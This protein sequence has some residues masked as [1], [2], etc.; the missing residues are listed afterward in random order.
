MSD[1]T[2]S[3]LEDKI[4]MVKKDLETLRAQGSAGRKLEIL[5][6]YLAYLEDEVKFLKN[7]KRENGY[8][9]PPR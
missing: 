8:Q 5:S 3:E 7:E 4:L 1:L 9:Q 2:I 6:E